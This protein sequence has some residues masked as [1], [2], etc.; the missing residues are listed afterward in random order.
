MTVK[1]VPLFATRRWFRLPPEK[2]SV[3]MMAS[4][5]VVFLSL[6][7][8][9]GPELEFPQ[10]KAY[11]HSCRIE[12]SYDRFADE[13]IYS[14]EVGNM[15]P[16]NGP[17]LLM[18]AKERFRGADRKVATAA[19]KI[20]VTF[21]TVSKNLGE[22]VRAEI[23][24]NKGYEVFFLFEG[25]RIKDLHAELTMTDQIGSDYYKIRWIT[26]SLPVREFL[27]L[28]NSELVE[29]RVGTREFRLTAQQRAG[30]KAFAARMAFDQSTLK[31]K[32]AEAGIGDGAKR[33]KEKGASFAKS[34]QKPDARKRAAQA[35]SRLRIAMELEKIDKATDAITFYNEIVE[36]YSDC[37]PAKTA[38][39]RLTALQAP[40]N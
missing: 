38:K 21:T 22:A 30:L 5:V 12:T 34:A 29:C 17:S 31:K 23:L 11:D 27:K 39:E 28:A 4:A 8:Q 25:G 35:E 13:S 1:A 32:L 3:T 40:K 37:P 26:V 16:V 14:I 24:F 18:S 20:E 9:P 33:S 6:I 2:G 15:N 36:K 10:L 7:V 19:T